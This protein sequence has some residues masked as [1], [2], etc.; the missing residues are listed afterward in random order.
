MAIVT[1][2]EMMAE[3]CSTTLDEKR[4][5]LKSGHHARRHDP[6]EGTRIVRSTGQ[7]GLK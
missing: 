5:I 6:N 7:C 2:I 4:E 1:L 3:I